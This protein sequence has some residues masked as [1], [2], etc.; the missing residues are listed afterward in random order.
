MCVASRISAFDA[1]PYPHGFGASADD[2]EEMDLLEPKK[3]VR[4]LLKAG[5]SLLNITIA[6]PHVKSHYCRPFDRPVN[7][8]AAPDEHPSR[9]VGRLLSIT[10]ALQHTYPELP[11]V[12]TGYSW[13]RHLFPNVAAAV[14]EAGDASLIG[15][16]RLAFAYPD[17]VNDLRNRGKMNPRK[18]CTTCSLCSQLMRS[19]KRTGC[20]TR[21]R[22]Y[23][24][25]KK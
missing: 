3:L 11:M 7:G 21:D 6:D 8:D 15:M 20:V 2:G 12:G 22:A 24:I 14:V 9:G 25:C 18:T 13:L 19:G 4:E 23:R 17:C 5:V 16:G 1:M 10:G